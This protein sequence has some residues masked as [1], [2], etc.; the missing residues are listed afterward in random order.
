MERVELHF[1]L[2]PGVDDGPAD[3]AGSL[4]LAREAVADGIGVITCTPHARDTD[5]TQIPER[6][7]KLSAELAAAG[8]EL[9]IRP[10]V[11][12][13]WN[14][15]PGLDDALLQTLAQGPADRRW[16]LLEAPLPGT[17]S[18]AD[19]EAAARELR[20]R[21]FG[22][23]VGHP[24]RSPALTSAPGAVDRLLAAGDRLQL[25]GS[26]L[27]GYHGAVPRT[28]GL[29][30][31]RSGRASVIAS[32]AHA[33]HA[34]GPSLGAAVDVLRRHGMP[35]AVAERMVA[36]TPRAL[37]DEGIEPARRLAA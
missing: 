12:L 22:V 24:E 20:E 35:A 8:I 29:D 5:V 14:D 18:L 37:L 2:L 7:R 32:D 17:G 33:P 15:L 9:E 36:A 31:A 11:E 30:L 25:N 19:Y 6:T 13:A 23:L 4:E 21:G 1:H 10:G 27:I 16:L 26:S 28:F 34:R 3:L